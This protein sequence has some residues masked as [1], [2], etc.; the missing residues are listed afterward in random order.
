MNGPCPRIPRH[1]AVVMD[2]NGRW[3]ESRGLPRAAGHRAGIDALRRCVNAASAA[4]VAA[5]T[6][7][8][9]SSE[10]W[11][12]PE[13]EV[14]LLMA[15]MGRALRR[16]SRRLAEHRIAV[17]VVGDRE[18]LSPVLCR[19]IAAAE[20]Q[21]IESPR[22]VLHVA[23]N[24]GGRWDILQAAQSLARAQPDPTG[25]TEEAMAQHLSMSDLPEVDLLIRTGGEYRISN[26]VLWQA[27]Y[28]ELLFLPTLWPDFSE[29]SFA[30]ALEMYAQRER[31]F[32]KT[33]AQVQAGAVA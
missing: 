31:R 23:F 27:A 24:Y 13:R 28:A 29:S 20:S 1:V 5:L 10:N 14:R 26:F 16:E 3:A 12:R 17:R 33:S 18:A 15:L 22:M 19:A 21:P 2:G 8:A 4:G 9:F 30:E 6:V 11:R 32:G 25:W 7:F